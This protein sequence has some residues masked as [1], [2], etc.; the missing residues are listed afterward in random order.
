MVEL[1]LTLGRIILK[2]QRVVNIY[3]LVFEDFPGDTF[4]DDGLT[5]EVAPLDGETSIEFGV[6]NKEHAQYV[7]NITGYFTLYRER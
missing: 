7:P 3:V 6:K 2:T 4:L 1:A 5:H